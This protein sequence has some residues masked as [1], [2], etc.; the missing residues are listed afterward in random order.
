MKRVPQGKISRRPNSHT[1][2]ARRRAGNFCGI[3]AQVSQTRVRDALGPSGDFFLGSE[4]RSLSAVSVLPARL[5][6]TSSR[7]W[8]STRPGLSRVGAF[9]GVAPKAFVTITN[10]SAMALSSECGRSRS[11]TVFLFAMY[12]SRVCSGRRSWDLS[13]LDAIPVMSC[14]ELFPCLPRYGWHG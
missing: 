3:W 11:R 2:Q 9:C 12:K 1:T 8:R 10:V 4:R 5:L 14:A 6:P 7:V 13:L